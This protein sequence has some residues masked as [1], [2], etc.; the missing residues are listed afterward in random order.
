M[1]T[2]FTIIFKYAPI[3][4]LVRSMP[5]AGDYNG[6]NGNINMWYPAP[7]LGTRCGGRADNGPMDGRAGGVVQGMTCN[8]RV[9]AIK[10]LRIETQV[11]FTRI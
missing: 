3:D 1:A 7:A 2:G 6:Q 8:R 4:S 11:T 9:M 5:N 10:S